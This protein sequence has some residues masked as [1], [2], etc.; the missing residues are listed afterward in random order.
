MQDLFRIHTNLF[1]LDWRAT[2][3]TPTVA[4]SGTKFLD[5]YFRATPRSK[6]CTLLTGSWKAW[7]VAIS[8]NFEAD[9]GPA[10]FE[11]TEY[12]IYARCK[13]TSNRITVV[14]RDP[15][16]I[17]RLSHQE[18]ET[19]LHGALN[20][21]GQIGRSTFTV[22]IND[23]PVLDLD[24]EVFPTKIDYETD[25]QEILA[26]LQQSVRSL[27]YEYLR[28][29][30]QFGKVTATAKPTQLEWLLLL[31][32]VIEQ[33]RKAIQEVAHHPRRGLVRRARVSRIEKIKKLNSVLRGQIRRGQGR[34][35]MLTTEVGC[36][37]EQLIDSS[38]ES[39]LDTAEHRWLKRQLT[40]IQQELARISQSFN[41]EEQSERKAAIVSEVVAMEHSITRMLT[42]EPIREA[43]GDPPPGFASLALLTS[44][45]YR[46]AYQTCMLLKMGLRLEGDAI[47]VSVK[48]LN[49]L[50]E[51]WV[52][53][54]MVQILRQA[55][56]DVDD[57]GNLFRLQRSGLHVGLIQGRQ[58]SIHFTPS[59]TS[60]ITITYN[61]QFQNKDTTLVPQKPDIL[62][63]C[64]H[65]GWPQLQ[66]ICDAK[67]RIDTTEEYRCQ[68]GIA[69]PPRDA[70]NVLHR[71]RDAILEFDE[72]D[73]DGRRPKRSVVQAAAL[74]PFT[75]AREGEFRESRLWTSI[76]RLGIG[77]I[78]ALPRGL[79]YL[80]EWLLG[81]I[82][83]GGWAMADRIIPNAVEERAAD[84]RD[85]ARDP[86]L[87]GVLDS[88]SAQARF[89]WI[90]KERLFY[91]PRPKKMHRHFR[92]V[93]VAL[94][95]P[96]PMRKTPAIAYVADVQEILELQRREID[97]PWSARGSGDAPML[98][99]RL[100]TIRSMPRV[101][102]NTDG[103][104][105]SFRGER[106]TTRLAL[107]RAVTAAEIAL[108][109]EP[110]W[111]LYE[112][113][114]SKQIKF[115]LRLKEIPGSL[116]D[117][118]IGRAAFR[119]PSGQS[120]RYDGSNGFEVAEGS[121]GMSRF[122]SFAQLQ[123]LLDMGST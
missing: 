29:T 114:H 88:A 4:S 108:E 112:L 41:R 25:Y 5:G 24:L 81:A 65:D 76:E 105:T 53:F 95:C 79:G 115:E 11:E 97:T 26:D 87:V 73:P 83:Q 104:Q 23:R 67:Y 91:I 16:I 32:E 44:P 52:F 80:R 37:R 98:V 1:S 109:T 51:Y 82:Q 68:F 84:W 72:F 58:Q 63:R 15:L 14:H 31:R 113:L 106:W 94:Y 70:I 99:Y 9:R 100:G 30:F 42:V 117:E 12:Q 36:V 75:E 64:E 3:R 118:P 13:S 102:E 119:L 66:L 69:G 40:E 21:R 59:K 8:N 111:R 110:E 54:A 18:N 28:S 7:P 96:R 60:R 33:L 101:L 2:S 38:P 20:F 92:V 39:T 71:Y 86:V 85:A 120:I 27:A 49:V 78:P 35:M 62:I 19:V 17:S 74:F 77:A 107:S 48:D 55:Y 57:F 50:Y 22:C 93:A 45:G 121:T 89:D 103:T 47:R 116:K 46:E 56:G 90:S 61:P 6:D 43:N 122:Y 123:Q 34:G 10:L